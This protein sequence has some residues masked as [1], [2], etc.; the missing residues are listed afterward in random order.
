MSNMLSPLRWTVDVGHW[1]KKPAEREG[2]EPSRA[3]NPT[4][5]PVARTRPGYATSPKT[6]CKFKVQSSKLS[7]SCELET[8]NLELRLGGGGGIRTHE[9]G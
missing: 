4:R 1:T 7:L 2:F 8:R 3:V 6:G 9:G 5:F